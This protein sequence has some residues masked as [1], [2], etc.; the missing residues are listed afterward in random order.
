[1]GWKWCHLHP[2][3]KTYHSGVRLDFRRHFE[4]WN[5]A[6]SKSPRTHFPVPERKISTR[7][8]MWEKK[9]KR[10]TSVLTAKTILTMNRIT[11]DCLMPEKKYRYI[12]WNYSQRITIMIV[13]TLTWNSSDC[14]D[15]IKLLLLS[16]S[17]VELV[18]ESE[19]SHSDEADS[20]VAIFELPEWDRQVS[21]SFKPQ[22]PAPAKFVERFLSTISLPA[23]NS[24][25][26][27]VYTMESGSC[28]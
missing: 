19:P 28:R 5:W 13:Y 16:S 27:R 21:E 7:R 12:M 4:H 24:S 10:K 20:V 8:K 23:T 18:E 14:A 26:T 2:H 3:Q 17:F 6:R 11:I 1:M 9:K 15:W 25:L 22:K